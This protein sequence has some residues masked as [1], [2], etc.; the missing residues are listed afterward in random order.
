MVP[1]GSISSLR[2]RRRRPPRCVVLSSL[3]ATPPW[4]LIESEGVDPSPLVPGGMPATHSPTG[5][6]CLGLVGER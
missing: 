4:P 6:R 2:L 1:G 3:A 5:A